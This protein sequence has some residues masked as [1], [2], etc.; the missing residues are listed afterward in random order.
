MGYH[1]HIS[2]TTHGPC[3]RLSPPFTLAYL[4]YDASILLEDTSILLEEY[5]TYS[6]MLVS[7]T[8]SL[9]IHTACAVIDRNTRCVQYKLSIETCSSGAQCRAPGPLLEPGTTQKLAAS[10]PVR[11]LKPLSKLFLNVACYQFPT[12]FPFP[13]LLFLLWAK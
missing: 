3:G 6:E 7:G 11:S 5:T 10:N 12:P 9:T 1:I 13:S 4:S 8:Q 2:K